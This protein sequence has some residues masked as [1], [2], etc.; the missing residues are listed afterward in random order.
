M[1]VQIEKVQTG[2]VISRF[3]HSLPAAMKGVSELEAIQEMAFNT[4]PPEPKPLTPEQSALI[5]KAEAQEAD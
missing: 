5:E 2:W 1:A 3:F 4:D